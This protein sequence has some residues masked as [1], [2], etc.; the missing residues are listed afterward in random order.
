MDVDHYKIY[1]SYNS[2]NDTIVS[3]NNNFID[4]DVDEGVEYFYSIAAV[5][6]SMFPQESMPT[7]A[8]SATPADPPILLDIWMSGVNEV[9]IKFDSKLSEN[10]VDVGLYTLNHGNNHPEVVYLLEEKSFLLLTFKENLKVTNIDIENVYEMIISGLEGINGVDMASNTYEFEFKLDVTAPEIT[11]YSIRSDKSI[12]LNF[13]ELMDSITVTD[14]SN[15]SLDSPITYQDIRI[16]ELIFAD[17]SVVIEFS[18]ELEVSQE[19]YTIITNDVKDN[20][21]NNIR[22][23]KN[24]CRFNL[25]EISSLKYVEAVPNPLITK[26]FDRISFIN[27]PLDKEGK[28]LIFDVSGVLVFEDTISPLNNFKNKYI[29]YAKNNS[30]KKVSTGIYFYIIKI[31]KELKKGKI[32]IIN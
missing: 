28:I 3:D 5:D 2:N 10:S 26:D 11:G 29:W 21:G 24:K 13:S 1:K 8:K 7:L 12:T 22:N 17:S 14:L 15:Y 4:Y 31:G 16:S 9:S 32:G 30:G 19:C 23:D 20:S 25:T 27:I 6:S 18:K